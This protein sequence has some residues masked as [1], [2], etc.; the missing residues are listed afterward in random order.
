MVHQVDGGLA[1]LDADVHVQAEDQVGA[2]HHLHVLDDVEVAR[3]RDRCPARASR[4]TDACR[5]RKPQAVLPG[6]VDHRRGA[7]SDVVLRFLDV[8][9]DAGADLDHRLVHLGLHALVQEQLAL[10]DD[11]GVDVR[12]QIA[13]DRIDGLVFLFDP[14]GEV[15]L[16]SFRGKCSLPAWFRLLKR[17][18]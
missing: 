16:G 9:A 11:F 1:I 6:Q 7:A 18:Q 13:R 17:A 5:R 15:G 8:A 3:R 10:L 14:D 12:A 2:R 4:R